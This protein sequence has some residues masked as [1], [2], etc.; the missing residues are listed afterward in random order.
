MADADS[1]NA[2]AD[3]DAGR[4]DEKGKRERA[5]ASAKARA[6]ANGKGPGEHGQPQRPHLAWRETALTAGMTLDDVQAQESAAGFAELDAEGRR[7]VM[8]RGEL[9]RAMEATARKLT[10]I[11]T[12]PIAAQDLSQAGA[13]PL[14][15]RRLQVKV[16][17]GRRAQSSR[18]IIIRQ[19]N[20][21]SA[22]SDG[23]G[24]LHR[25]EVA[26]VLDHPQLPSTAR[27]SAISSLE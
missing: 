4:S 11:G 17:R 16:G 24:A 20:A 27:V 3:A 10:G 18:F 1:A 26:A 2:D 12:R 6:K 7:R 15:L 9:R 23:F 19:A 13:L 22:S 14:P 21:R 25:G 8:T 5:R